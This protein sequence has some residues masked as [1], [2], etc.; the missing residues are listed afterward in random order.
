MKC[1]KI[2]GDWGLNFFYV[3]EIDLDKHSQDYFKCNKYTDIEKDK[4]NAN[5][6]KEELQKIECYYKFYI[7]MKN[8]LKYFDK[9]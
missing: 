4:K 5:K 3:C 1:D 2:S 7:N 8:L 6:W 9:K